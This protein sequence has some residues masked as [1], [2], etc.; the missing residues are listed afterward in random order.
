MD[1]KGKTINYNLKEKVEPLGKP[2][3][4]I[5]YTPKGSSALRPKPWRNT[6]T[7]ATGDIIKIFIVA[8]LFKIV[9]NWKQLKWTH[10]RLDYCP[11]FPSLQRG[12]R[13]SCLTDIGVFIWLV[14]ASG[15]WADV[16]V[17]L[18]KALFV[19]VHPP[20]EA[21]ISASRRMC[22]GEPAGSRR[23]RKLQ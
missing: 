23:M 17:S 20:W 13:V 14:F 12:S 6:Y 9:I 18:R 7:C 21:A 5:F 15:M 2:F 8:A 4:I 11:P 22:P 3:D 10:R 19:S 16:T 1:I